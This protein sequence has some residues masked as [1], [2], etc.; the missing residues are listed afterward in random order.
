MLEIVLR[1]MIFPRSLDRFALG[2]KIKVTAT[3]ETAENNQREFVPDN[4]EGLSFAVGSGEDAVRLADLC[5][6]KELLSTFGLRKNL[7]RW[8]GGVRQPTTHRVLNSRI[9]ECDRGSEP[10]K[11]HHEYRKIDLI[12]APLNVLCVISS[13]CRP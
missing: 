7:R 1:A 11:Y 13:F 12:V 5:V 3:R 4:A 9:L 6:A 10:F 8:F 2:A